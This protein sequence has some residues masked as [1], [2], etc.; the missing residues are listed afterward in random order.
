M[1]NKIIAYTLLRDLN[2]KINRRNM[3]SLARYVNCSVSVRSG[4]LQHSSHIPW[5]VFSPSIHL[6]DVIC[7][8]SRG[9]ILIV[10]YT[11]HE[12]TRQIFNFLNSSSEE[13]SLASTEK[14]IPVF[15]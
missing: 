7:F 11:C 6:P 1:R 4:N 9:Q 14:L 8:A 15:K 12:F 10:F 13:K 2:K 3:R 5:A